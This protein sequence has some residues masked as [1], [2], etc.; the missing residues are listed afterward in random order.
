MQTEQAPTRVPSAAPA[1]VPSS[2]TGSSVEAPTPFPTSTVTTEVPQFVPHPCG[3]EA[4][5]DLVYASN[6]AFEGAEIRID[7][8]VRLCQDCA[9]RCWR[10]MDCEGFVF[11]AYQVGGEQGACTYY[12]A[13]TGHSRE[14]GATSISKAEFVRE[15]SDVP[16]IQ[17][18]TPVPEPAEPS[19]A[20]QFVSHPCGAGSTWE[21]DL[22]VADG[23]VFRG[24]SIRTDGGLHIC[25][26]CAARCWLQM[27]GTCKG[28]VFEPEDGNDVGSCTYFSSISGYETTTVNKRAITTAM[29]V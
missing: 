29:E 1:A 8:G 3:N 21:A 10:Q 4:W 18:R 6:L 11:R 2:M 13:I 22:V 24:K 16:S 26:D 23:T 17:P 5:K 28:F 7:G 19:R 25:R 15:F 27:H 12:S 20:S 14:D 9:E